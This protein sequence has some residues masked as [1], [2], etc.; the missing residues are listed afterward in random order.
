MSLDGSGGILRRPACTALLVDRDEEARGRWR[1]LLE[2]ED[3]IRIVGETDNGAAAIRLV[4]AH[5]PQLALI[6]LTLPDM[7]GLAVL[8]QMKE[9]H[10][11][12]KAIVLS[13]TADLGRLFEAM[14]TGAHGFMLSD[15]HPAWGHEY[16]RSIVWEDASMSKALV[17]H[18]LNA[19]MGAYIRELAA[20]R[21]PLHEECFMRESPAGRKGE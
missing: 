14:K 7:S 18:F 4:Q 6:H 5:A 10:P 20:Q 2:L 9:R 21:P 16:L 19:F 11:A 3:D 17:D 15:M 12:L 8:R 1:S 13:E